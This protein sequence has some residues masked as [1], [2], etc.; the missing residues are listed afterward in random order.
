MSNIAIIIPAFKHNYLEET[1]ESIA[2]QDLTDCHIYI[3]DDASPHPIANIVKKFEKRIPL[4]YTRFN[5]NLGGKDLVAQWNR[6][7]TLANGEQW[8]WLFSDDDIMCEGCIEK[9]R[10]YINLHNEE[11]D[12]YH[13]NGTVIDNENKELKIKTIV[14]FPEKL[15]PNEYLNHII[16][17]RDNTWGI[18]YVVRRKTIENCN[19]FVNFD[20]AWNSDRASWLT[21]CFPNGIRTI[22][23]ARVLWRYSGVNITSQKTDKLIYKRKLNARLDFLRWLRRNYLDVNRLNISNITILIYSLR[24]FKGDKYVCLPFRFLVFIRSLKLLKFWS[25]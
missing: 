9:V 24:N 2:I 13:I 7:L 11:C 22:P 23:E 19:G 6:C 1:L 5:D 15:T 20:L 17:G 12:V 18:N 10:N 3:G 21:F 8:I 16:S 14:D 4:S 25:I